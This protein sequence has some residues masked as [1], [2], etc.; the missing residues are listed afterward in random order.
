MRCSVYIH[1]RAEYASHHS[2]FVYGVYF[3]TPLVKLVYAFLFGLEFAL[4][5]SYDNSLHLVCHIVL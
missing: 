4:H 3:M 1:R 2:F 5:D